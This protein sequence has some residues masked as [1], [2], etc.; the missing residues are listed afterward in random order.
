MWHKACNKCSWL[1]S[2]LY[3]KRCDY[4]SD[5][6]SLKSAVTGGRNCSVDVKDFN[7]RLL[8]LVV[9]WIQSLYKEHSLQKIIILLL[10]YCNVL[11]KPIPNSF[12][13]ATVSS[14][15]TAGHVF[16]AVTYS[17]LS[18]RLSA[19]YDVLIRIH[20]W[21]ILDETEK[22]VSIQLS[23]ATCTLYHVKHSQ[24]SLMLLTEHKFQPEFGVI[25]KITGYVRMEDLKIWRVEISSSHSKGMFLHVI[26]VNTY[27]ALIRCE[28]LFQAL[29]YVY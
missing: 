25:F 7:S 17:N 14:S 13:E 20:Y 21:I 24:V 27:M 5:K 29:Y 6:L 8:F 3:F 23:L 11:T 4:C 26:T 18:Q 9:H 2:L 12:S 22:T 15:H 16:E 28:V 10:L 1:L 19:V